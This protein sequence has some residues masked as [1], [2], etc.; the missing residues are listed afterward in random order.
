MAPNNGTDAGNGAGK[1]QN[2][3]QRL[4]RKAKTKAAKDREEM[5]LQDQ[6]LAQEID[7]D[8]HP[9]LRKNER[10]QDA[11]TNAKDDGFFFCPPGIHPEYTDLFLLQSKS[12]CSCNQ[13]NSC[14]S[15]AMMTAVPDHNFIRCA[16][17]GKAAHKV[18]SMLIG[19]MREP[20]RSVCRACIREFD[21]V[22]SRGGGQYL[23][24]NPKLDMLMEEGWNKYDCRLVLCSPSKYEEVLQDIRI[25]S[26]RQAVDMMKALASYVDVDEQE[27]EFSPPPLPS[28]DDDDDDDDDDLKPS[29]T[30]K[31]AKRPGKKQAPKKRGGQKQAGKKGGKKIRTRAAH[32]EA[33]AARKASKEGEEKQYY[34][35]LT[36]SNTSKAAEAVVKTAR[37]A[38]ADEECAAVVHAGARGAQIASLLNY[39]R[40][41]VIQR[42]AFSH[43]NFADKFS[44]KKGWPAVEFYLLVANQLVANY[45]GTEEVPENGEEGWRRN[46]TNYIILKPHAGANLYR[47]LLDTSASHGRFRIDATANVGHFMDCFQNDDIEDADLDPV[48]SAKDRMT[49]YRA[50]YLEAKEDYEKLLK[51]K[52]NPDPKENKGGEAGEGTKVTAFW[53]KAKN[54]ATAATT[55]KARSKKALAAAKKAKAAAA[56]KAAEEAATK[57]AEEEA[58]AKKAEEAAAAKK[59]AEEAAAAKKAAEEAAAAKK[60][61]NNGDNASTRHTRSTSNAA[62]NTT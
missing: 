50:K 60:A 47:D 20:P 53:A 55:T 16:V 29:G 61:V 52:N 2:K 5:E 14:K 57:K 38:A 35:L 30:K 3:R 24:S 28:D 21:L 45:G 33:K 51:K 8:S 49:A 32:E 1:N 13:L 9:I 10:L 26:N 36:K 48:E 27:D 19:E 56:K 25:I 34:G 44:G 37:Q 17:C 7:A 6:L 18:C 62:T 12:E 40:R 31:A 4:E 59:T 58:A 11:I 54:A 46:V 41:L 23:S 22:M 39:D 42:R 43:Q 15:L